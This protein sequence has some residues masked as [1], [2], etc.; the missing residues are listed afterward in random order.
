MLNKD[1]LLQLLN[2]ERSLKEIPKYSSEKLCEYFGKDFAKQK[3]YKQNN[4]HHCY[5]LLNHTVNTVLAVQSLKYEQNNKNIL[6]V[7][8]LYHDVGKPNV[9]RVKKDRYV[10][11]NHEKESS[12]LAEKILKEI[13][14]ESDEIELI[15]F[16]IRNHGVFMQFRLDCEMSKSPYLKQINKYTFESLY[17]SLSEDFP[18]QFD[19]N[20]LKMLCDLSISDCCAQ[21]ETV[22]NGSDIIDTRQNKIKRI[23]EIK[24]IAENTTV[25]N[26][27]H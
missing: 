5:D 17:Q 21:S 26:K 2:D 25:C 24:R 11:Y 12:L 14:F 23:D 16:L 4:P 8:A 1:K 20:I 22:Y 13:G 27:S 19:T 18:A 9:M 10:F 7:A 15:C 3:D 6:L